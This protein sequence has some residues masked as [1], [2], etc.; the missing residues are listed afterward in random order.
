MPKVKCNIGKF[1]DKHRNFL[2][3]NSTIDREGARVAPLL[4]DM[5]GAIYA[6]LRETN[7]SL[8]LICLIN[9]LFFANL[10]YL[11]LLIYIYIYN[12]LLILYKQILYI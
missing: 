5:G 7:S 6:F 9:Y 3:L 1:L 8:Y 10:R 4:W 11:Y 2:F 12:I